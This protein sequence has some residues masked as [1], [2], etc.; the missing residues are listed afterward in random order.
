M[1]KILTISILLFFAFSFIAFSQESEITPEETPEKPAGYPEVIN[2]HGEMVLVEG[3]EFLMG[4]DKSDIENMIGILGGS[5]SWYIL[6]L[7]KNK[8]ELPSFYIDKYEVTNE[9]FCQFLNDMGTH[10][11]EGNETPWIMIS[12]RTCL[13]YQEVSGTY[14]PKEGYENYPAIM[15]SWYGAQE[16]AKWAGKRLPTEAEWEKAAR[17]TK[18]WVWPW[19]NTWDR[20]KCNSW[21]LT[22]KELLQLMP[23]IYEGRGPLPVGSFPEITSSCGAFD[24]AGNAAEWCDEWYGMYPGYPYYAGDNYYEFTHKVTRGGSW[25]INMPGGLSCSFR[26][27]HRT[28]VCDAYTGFRCCM[29]IPVDIDNYVK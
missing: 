6:Q 25:G 8:V 22:K 16:Y 20:N 7:P 21:L 15:V 24:M 23:D 13:I 5:K 19:G 4:S 3:G 28:F 1:K 11:E 10:R 18:G 26:S 12:N 29:D 9:E 14:R 17:G 27:I 2:H